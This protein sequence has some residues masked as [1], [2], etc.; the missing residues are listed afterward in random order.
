VIRRRSEFEL[1]RARERGH[2]LEGLL[3]AL[4][5]LDDI[6]AT[7]RKAEDAERASLALQTRFGLPE[8]QARAILEMQLRRLA[9]LER[10]KIEDEYKQVRDRIAYLEDLLRS[11][12]KVLNLI[13]QD[14]LEMAQKYGDDRRDAHHSWG[15]DGLRGIRPDRGRRSARN[16]HPARLHQAGAVGGLSPPDARRQGRL[17]HGNTRRGCPRTHL[18]GGQPGSHPVLLRS[19]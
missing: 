8:A 17:R 2:I 5:S 4:A 10:Q 13:K 6:I 19:R 16:L 12:H 11:P 18:R 7:I 9:A 1:A 15:R 3:K 14:L